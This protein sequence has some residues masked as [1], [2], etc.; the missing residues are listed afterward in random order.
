MSMQMLRGQVGKEEDGEARAEQEEG[1]RKTESA[2]Q[3]SIKVQKLL[4]VLHS[5]NTRNMG[6]T[7]F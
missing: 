3:K 5:C 6:H 2:Y 4:L 1:W 7:S